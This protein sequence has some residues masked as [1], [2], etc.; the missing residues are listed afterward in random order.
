MVKG[1]LGINGKGSSR[2]KW[3]YIV[4]LPF[5]FDLFLIQV[6]LFCLL[7]N[8]AQF[9]RIFHNQ[10]ND[11]LPYISIITFL[12]AVPYWNIT[13]QHM[14][15]IFFFFFFFLLNC[16]CWLLPVHMHTTL[17]STSVHSYHVAIVDCIH[18]GSSYSLLQG[19]GNSC[20]G[21]LQQ[22]PSRCFGKGLAIA[23][24]LLANSFQ[25]A[26]TQQHSERSSL[27]CLH[28]AYMIFT[29]F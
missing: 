16:Y 29:Q 24:L 17:N 15:C 25:R 11:P 18:V 10:F 7:E 6:G 5:L 9:N 27:F 2:C 23:Y 26:R 12:R 1:H 14:P 13:H 20:T 3:V 8:Y 19:P 21:E 4:M 28:T 22:P